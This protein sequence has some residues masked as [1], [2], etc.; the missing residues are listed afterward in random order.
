MTI[1]IEDCRNHGAPG[2]LFVGPRYTFAPGKE[3]RK[4]VEEAVFL[5]LQGTAPTV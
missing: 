2:V 3:H 4:G 5:E 1:R